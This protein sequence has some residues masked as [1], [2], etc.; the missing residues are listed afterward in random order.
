[1][2][3]LSF[4]APGERP[5]GGW[6]DRAD[7]FLAGKSR[8]AAERRISPRRWLSCERLEE[9]TLLAT[10]GVDYVV[11]GYSW[12]NPSPITYSIAPDGVFWD[13][14]TNVLNSTFNAEFG[15]SGIWEAQIAR[16]L[17]TWESVANIN[18]VPVADGPYDENTLGL[19]QGDPRF[20]DIRIGGYPYVDNTTTLSLTCPPP[21]QGSTAAG[22]VE[23]NTP[24]SYGIGSRYDLYS[25][26]LHEFGRALG[27]DAP[28]NPAEVMCIQYQG[29]RTGL[30]A[31]DIAGIQ[32]IYGARPFDQYQAQGLGI[33]FGSPIDVTSILA[34]SNQVTLPNLSLQS[35][36]DS[37]YFSFVAP[38]YASDSLQISAIATQISMLS[39]KVS[40]YDGAGD[41]LGQASNP[42]SWSDTVT[43]TDPSV[44]PG[45]RYYVVVSGATG[46][47][48][49][50]GAY[51][52]SVS[53]PTSSPVSNPPV[54]SPIPVPPAPTPTPSP[55]PISIPPDR[56]EPNS[57]PVTATPLG[58]VTQVT[59]S[60]LNFTTGTD[61][62]Y[63][64]FQTGTTGIFD[65]SA[66]GATIQVL[67]LKGKLVASGVNQLSL[68]QE[69]AGTWL[70][71]RTSSANSTA[72]ANYSLA[73]SLAPQPKVSRH[74]PVRA[75]KTQKPAVLPSPRLARPAA[76]TKMA[77]R[78]ISPS[79][80]LQLAN[81]E[82]VARVLAAENHRQLLER[83]RG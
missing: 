6:R 35:I 30:A 60:G 21:P 36:G 4:A 5:G 59:E 69:R 26:M 72:L 63:F 81:L 37:E 38:S 47:V 55:A 51:N 50:A 17:A 75:V 23:I 48:F 29:I 33:G 15:T 12:P 13:H 57:S 25:V 54:P 28:S 7:G 2:A 74:H 43:V 45:Q 76:V 10:P 56:F 31:G 82:P 46:G 49:D 11:T 9:R 39:P 68:P 24:M 44:V 32:A 41:L 27:L 80:R 64:R 67:T 77:Q 61:L 78:T 40:L 16:A 3:W 79:V 70:I 58:R 53:L 20:G 34:L 83:K 14:G 19:A 18:V 1:M 65:I 73:I 42:S 71:V 8:S 52:L 22:D 66:A 62:D